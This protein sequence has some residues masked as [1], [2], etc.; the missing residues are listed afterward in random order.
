VIRLLNVKQAAEMLN[1]KV[2]TIYAWVHKK[3]L[4]HVKLHG[5]LVFTVDQLEEFIK[6]NTF[7][8]EL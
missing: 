5:K 1:I 3:K 2:Q 4:P 8:P 7:R 6:S